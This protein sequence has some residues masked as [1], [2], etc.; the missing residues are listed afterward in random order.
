MTTAPKTTK[1]TVEIVDIIAGC[2]YQ[3]QLT[4]DIMYEKVRKLE[5]SS[6][7]NYMLN[8]VEKQQ[9]DVKKLIRMIKESSYRNQLKED[10]KSTD[11]A[12]YAAVCEFAREAK[13]LEHLAELVEIGKNVEDF[14]PIITQLRAIMLNHIELSKK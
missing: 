13:D 11:I 8:Y 2:A 14:Q 1:A 7:K 5:Y 9:T 4:Y 3:A 10:L 12:F 6:L